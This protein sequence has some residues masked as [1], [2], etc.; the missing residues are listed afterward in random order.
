MAGF[1]NTAAAGEEHKRSFSEC[2]PRVDIWAPG[3]YIMGAYANK[4][5]AGAAIQDSRNT[6]YYLNK[7]SGTSQACPQVTGVVA[8]LLQIRPWFTATNCLNWI[9]GVA[10]DWPVNEN[11]YGGSGYTNLGSLQGSPKKALYNPF[12]SSD[13]LKIS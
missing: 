11:Y 3:D 4:S 9:N 10:T 1:T 7:I 6:A 2:G 5:Y 13:S 12:K 8:C